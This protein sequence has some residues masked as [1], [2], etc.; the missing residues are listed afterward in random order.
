MV[1][2]GERRI[3]RI[4]KLCIF[5]A[6]TMTAAA[7]CELAALAAETS[8]VTELNGGWRLVRTSNPRGGQQAVSIM[9]TADTSQSDLDLAGLMIRC[10]RKRPEVIIV[11]LR[12]FSLKARPTVVLGRP[13]NETRLV[14]KVVAPGTAVDRP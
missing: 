4:R 14:A 7:Q 2:F 6:F 1:I 12:A 11:L 5:F 3:F 13:G 8:S 9:R 10:G